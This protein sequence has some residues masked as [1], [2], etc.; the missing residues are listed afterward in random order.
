M[1]TVVLSNSELVNDASKAISKSS[2]KE[3]HNSINGKE[4]KYPVPRRKREPVVRDPAE[5]KALRDELASKLGLEGQELSK[6]QRKHLIRKAEKEREA[7]ERKNQSSKPE[8]VAKE[9]DS[10]P[11]PP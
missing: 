5:I 2:I 9:T 8:P 4:K 7:A 1:S 11:V 6:S 3:D 10:S